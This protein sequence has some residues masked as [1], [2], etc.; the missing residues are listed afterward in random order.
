MGKKEGDHRLHLPRDSVSQEV[1]L[2]NRKVGHGCV[3]QG[4]ERVVTVLGNDDVTPPCALVLECLALD[5]ANGLIDGERHTVP[6]DGWV[7]NDIRIRKLSLHSIESFDELWREKF[8][9][10]YVS[11]ILGFPRK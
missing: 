11:Q 8:F 10:K 7:E 5:V 1:V 6:R 3:H 9:A 2:Q 4:T